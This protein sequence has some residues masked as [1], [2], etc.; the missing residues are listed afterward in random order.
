MTELPL[1]RARMARPIAFPIL[2]AV[3]A[4]S[5]TPGRQ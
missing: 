4:I 1:A 2:S 5:G 3:G